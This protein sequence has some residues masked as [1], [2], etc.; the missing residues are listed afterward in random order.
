MR[1]SRD[2]DEARNGGGEK[3]MGLDKLGGRRHRDGLHMVGRELERREREMK[4]SCYTLFMEM[5]DIEGF[6]IRGLR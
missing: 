6:Y 4:G 1:A 5:E 2:L 3:W